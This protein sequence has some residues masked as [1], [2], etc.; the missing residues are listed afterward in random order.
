MPHL[1]PVN[2]SAPV[3]GA[4]YA[5][6]ALVVSIVLAAGPAFA[7]G[8]RDYD[9]AGGHYYESDGAGVGFVVS[10]DEA[11]PLWSEFRR[12]GGVAALGSPISRRYECDGGI[13]QVFEYAVFK[14][15][16]GANEVELLSVFDW[17]HLQG[18]DDWLRERWGVPPWVRATGKD[19]KGRQK[20]EQEAAP[21]LL[22][23]NASLKAAYA[24]PGPTAPTV[25]GLARSY[26]TT[27]TSAVLRTQRAVLVHPLDKPE[28]VTLLGAGEVFREA[29]LLPAAALVPVE[30]PAPSD[31]TPPTRIQISALEI[32]AQVITLDMG[33]DM[34]LPI[35]DNGRVVAWYSYGA[36]LGEGGNAVLAGHV[37]WNHELAV[38]WR[39]R[40]AR[41]GQTVT[42]YG[43]AGQAYDYKIEW[44]RDYPEAAAEGIAELRPGGEATTIT[45][46]TCT[47]RFDAATRSYL[48]R[49]MVRATLVGRRG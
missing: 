26:W 28:E 33:P 12:L 11:A 42:L 18:R 37:D 43:V 8:P 30:A 41:P 21:A 16:P 4:V 25:Y 9:V 23:A 38:F 39:L 47:G 1:M 34:I 32:D 36:R 48:D 3:R 14:W 44:V 40:E 24:R 22:A 7:E 10:D 45:L 15:G 29:E 5:T 35:P 6:L 2:R 31:L 19:E 49:R 46:V 20:K 17:L 13:C 27:E